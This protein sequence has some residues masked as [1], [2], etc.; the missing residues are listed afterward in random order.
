MMAGFVATLLGTD[1]N[2]CRLLGLEPKLVTSCSAPS[3]K[4]VDANKAAAVAN[5]FM[6]RFEELETVKPTNLETMVMVPE[7]R[8]LGGDY[9]QFCLSI[10]SRTENSSR[11]PP[12]HRFKC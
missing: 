7:L 8:N 1:M 5:N 10:F 11:Q 4:L 3:T 9:K 6:I 12:G 2:I